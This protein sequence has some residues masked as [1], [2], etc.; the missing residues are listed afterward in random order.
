MRRRNLVAAIGAYAM[1]SSLAAQVTRARVG[2]LSVYP[3]QAST[4]R[5]RSHAIF[6]Q[7]MQELG[8]REGDNFTFELRGRLVGESLET[9]VKALVALKC[10]VLISRGTE[11]VKLLRDASADV[12]IVMAGVGD[13]VG[14]GLV[15]SLAHPGGNVTGV[16]MVGQELFIK[17]VSMLREV[18]PQ[19]KRVDLLTTVSN[20]ASAFF[21]RV[22]GEAARSQGLSNGVLEVRS[23]DELERTIAATPADA[24]VVNSDPTFFDHLGRM[25]SAARRRGLPMACNDFGELTRAGGLFS[26]S[27]DGDDITKLTADYTDRILRGAKPAELPVAQPRRYRFVIN[28]DTARSLG[29]SVSAA[30]LML[31]DEVIR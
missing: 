12:P 3:P 6:V 23:P 24:L 20:P 19:A 9:A 1:A 4:A 15:K 29:L 18:A 14:T 8:W 28:L 11:A 13:P 25:A 22:I 17:I 27:P 30:Q 26:Y 5:D 2:W 16:S 7:R 10:D 21:A 31:A